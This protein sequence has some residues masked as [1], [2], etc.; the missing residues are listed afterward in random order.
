[1]NA[2]KAEA[3]RGCG[4][5][6]PDLAR[7]LDAYERELAQRGFADHAERVRLAL[8]G[9]GGRNWAIV[10]LDV[11]PRTKL[12]NELLVRVIAS[13]RTQL[14][15]RLGPAKSAPPATSLASL[16][17]YLFSNDAVPLREEDGTVEI[18]S[19]S[20]E[21]L[22]C[23]EIARRIHRAAERGMPFDEIAIL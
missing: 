20:G 15:L 1:L 13:A 9:V 7:L 5:S 2:V 12:E 10:S 8:S 16:Q 23:V 22:E 14:D 6:G 19:T 18:F 4:A 17:R 11:V 3:L 21:A